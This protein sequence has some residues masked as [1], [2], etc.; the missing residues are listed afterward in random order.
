MDQVVPAGKTPD[1]KSCGVVTFRKENGA[2]QY[3]I[4]HYPSGHFDFPKGHV[5]DFDESEHETAY[6]ELE[7]ETGIETLEFYPDFR[8][9][10]FYTYRRKGRPS[11]K[12]VVFFVGETTEKEITISHEH[13]DSIWLPYEEAHKKLICC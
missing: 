4:L 7:E 11:Y 3:L 5:E 12:Q 9:E 13:Q 2:R 8:E 1:E 6:R 10:V